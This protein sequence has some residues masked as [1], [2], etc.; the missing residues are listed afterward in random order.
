M[1]KLHRT[2]SDHKDFQ[3]LTALFDEFLVDIDGDEKDFFA[4]YNQIYIENVVVFYENEIPLGCG[5]FKELEPSIAEIKRMFVV[6]EGRGK[7]IAT[8]ILNELESWTKE[9]NY[10]SCQLETSQ[11]LEN[12]IAL[13]KKFGY[14]IIPNYGQYEGV[15]SSICMKKIF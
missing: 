13:Y 12:A 4:Q 10:T 15:E 5:A 2:N 6:P 7:G 9:L 8:T 14:K 11:K 1:T 3:K